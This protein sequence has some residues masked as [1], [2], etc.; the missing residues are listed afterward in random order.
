MNRLP[1]RQIDIDDPPRLGRIP[2]ARD[3]HVKTLTARV[4]GDEANVL[5]EFLQVADE[6]WSI[7]DDVQAA[8]ALR[9]CRNEVAFSHCGDE[10]AHV[11]GQR[12]ESSPVR[13]PRRET[14]RAIGGNQR[15]VQREIEA[16]LP[17]N[18]P[19]SRRRRAPLPPRR[20]R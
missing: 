7:D 16:F 2:R 12:K 14:G 19:G 13:A 11:K 4:G 8:V 1:N 6:A 15:L 18:R 10:T 5:Q 3:G 17:P 9:S 20:A